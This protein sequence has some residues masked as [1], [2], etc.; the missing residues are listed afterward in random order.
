M[1]I[2]NLFFYDSEGLVAKGKCFF[3]TLII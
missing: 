3:I 2:L 1:A